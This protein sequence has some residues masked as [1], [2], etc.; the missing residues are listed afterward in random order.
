MAVSQHVVV[1]G[2]TGFLGRALTLRLLGD[3]YR[4]TAL[5]RSPE[6]ARSLLPADAVVADLSSQHAL[7][8]AIAAA[9]AVVNLAGEGI[10]DR[11]WTTAR[12]RLLRDSRITVTRRLVEAIAERATPLPVLVSASAV[13]WYG[14]RGDESLDDR[15]PPGSGFAAELC[16][17]WEA[18]AHAAV[19]HAARVVRARIGVVLGREGGALRKLVPLFR[20]G[21]GGRI[22]RG[23]QWLP[24]I[25]LDD[26]IAA[27]VHTIADRRIAGPVDLV[28]PS[29]VRQVDF[30][31]SLGRAL[32]RWAIVPTPRLAPAVIMG[33]AR[34]V[35]LASQHVRPRV[36]LDTGFT[37]RYP[38][39]DPALA[40][41]VEDGV[42]LGPVDAAHLPVSAYLRDRRPRYQ[43]VASTE[44]AA[45][46]ADVF[47]FFSAAE[48]L[49]AITPPGLGFTIQTPRPIRIAEG[50][51]IDY[52]IRVGG[53]AM[54]WRTTIERWSPG[55]SFVD[56]QV[57]GPYRAWWHEHRFVER[58][59]KT[60]MEDRVLYAPPFGVLGRIANALF[61]GPML[62]RIFGYR[63]QAIRARFERGRTFDAGVPAGPARAV[64]AWYPAP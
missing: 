7:S 43:L 19:P 58:A 3:G 48:N 33:S 25:H 55:E 42:E 34:A 6:R 37:F 57:A 29:P 41:L 36:L 64:G 23:S 9:D 11:R 47:A 31:R 61:I 44:L 60:V 16:R 46:L 45:P 1:I 59:G 21:L 38:T 30:A 5:A 56:T 52:R 39:L 10:A 8:T 32:H 13:G 24:W 62:R 50:T 4:V 12:R 20:A 54:R 26:A 49:A 22:G 14:D 40:D 18:A 51:S 35:L 27:L 28:A 17:D 53:V 15:S 63:R 2:A